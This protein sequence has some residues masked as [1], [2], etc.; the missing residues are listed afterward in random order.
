MPQNRLKGITIELSGDSTKLQASLKG[1][2]SEI[3]NTQSQLKDVERLLKLD[4]G[5]TELLAQKHKLLGQ[6]VDATKRKLE[7]LKQ[8]NEQVSRSAGNYD[9]WKAKYDPIQKEITETQEHLKKLKAQAA[10]AEKQLAEGKISQEKYDAIQTELKETSDHLKDLKQQARD[11][12]EEFGHPVSPEQYDALQREIVETTAELKKLEDQARQSGT[13]VQDIAAKGEKLKDLGGKVENAGKALLPVTGAVVGLGTAAVKTTADFDSSMSKVSAVS[14]ATGEELDKLRAKAREMGET[15]Q[16]SASEAADAMNYMAMAGWKTKDMLDGIDGIMNLAAASGEDLATTSDI[17]TD[18]LTAFGM[19]ADESGHFADIL[20]AASSNANTNVSMLG[21]SFKYVAPVAGAMGYNAEDVSLALGLMANSGIKASSAGTSLRNILTNM[22]NP[23]DKMSAAMD[24]LGIELDDGKGNM[25]SLREIMQNLRTGFGELKIPAD[26]AAAA[27]AD[28]DKQLEDGTIDQKE[29][30]KQVADLT[31]RVFGAE[32]AVKAQTAAMLAGKNGMSGLMALINASDEDY[33]KLTGA[34]DNCS[35]TFVKT[36]DGA[37]LPMSEALEQGI[38]WVEGYN[39]ASEQMAATM[40]DN[41]GGQLKILISQLQELA[42]SLGEIMMPIIRDIVT[43]LQGLVD[44]LNG[45]DDGTKRIIIT[46]AAVA[47]ALGPL[48]IFVGKV[49]GAVGTIMT[50]APKIQGALTLL[51]GTVFP[52]VKAALASLWGVLMANP[53]ILIVAAVAALVAAFIYFWNTSEGFRQF[54]INLWENI[55]ATAMAVWE[56][57]S[58]FFQTA[59]E[60]IVNIAATIWNGLKDFFSGLWAGIQEI[61]STV[62][63]TIVTIVTTY[64]TIYRT[65]I[66]TVLSAIRT[67]ITTIWN[68]IKTYFTAVFKGILAVVRAYFT[69]YKTV[70]TTVLKAIRT[71]VTTIWKA[72]S[73]FFSKVLGTIGTN[74]QKS[75]AA[76][77]KAISDR[78]SAVSKVVKAVWSAI[79]TIFGNSL[80]AVYNAVVKVFLA[81]FNGIKRVMKAVM[82]VVKNAFT[83]VRNFIVGLAKSAYTWGRD[84]IMG[85]VKGIRSAIGSVKNAVTDV[86]NSIK[87]ILHFSVPDEG[88]LTDYENWMPD[89][90]R[91]LA[92]G[93]E[94]NRPLVREAM[95]KVADDIFILP[96]SNKIDLSIPVDGDASGLNQAMIALLLS[97]MQPTEELVEALEKL[98]IQMDALRT[99]GDA[100]EAF[101]FILGEL[102]APAEA[103][104]GELIAL[105]EMLTVGALT[106]DEYSFRLVDLARRSLN[107]ADAARVQAAALLVAENGLTALIALASA[108]EEELERL[109][110][111]VTQVQPPELPTLEYAQPVVPEAEA[112][113]VELPTLTYPQPIVPEAEIPATH[114]PAPDAPDLFIPDYA[115]QMRRAIDS[116]VTKIENAR[117]PV[118]SAMAAL[119]ASLVLTPTLEEIDLPPEEQLQPF[120]LSI[121]PEMKGFLGTISS[122]MEVSRALLGTAMEN[123]STDLM[124]LPVAQTASVETGRADQDSALGGTLIAMLAEYL[125]YLPRL[126]QLQVRL[127]NGTLVGQLAPG[128]DERLGLLAKRQ[129]RQ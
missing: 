65:I 44:W 37:I 84:L 86:A 76:I 54:W 113:D 106:E 7:A 45:L 14:G 87:S 22:A 95:G 77:Q 5:N 66:T 90:L 9:A 68:A 32:G 15:T 50:W 47:A 2:T 64:F 99:P 80:K 57:L 24:K 61:F 117:A 93:I 13:A 122:T 72:I 96:D 40:N 17:V 82:T 79:R 60:T 31:E 53:I 103:V 118:Q 28:L 107:V 92:Q 110:E 36:A 115:S 119:S 59:W 56:A 25:L 85:I 35:Q 102:K 18:A 63:Q 75:F 94:D 71:V 41:L 42:I 100:L 26:E 129:R 11:V 101:R 29:Y 121:L 114:L 38:D 120:T 62:L 4:P 74:V 81:I 46:V 39:G 104:R 1:V 16:F 10:D 67:V 83:A 58:G 19:S 98:G 73:G 111:G 48:L 43:K 116:I 70:I 125:P 123:G 126:A 49:M 55:K 105:N 91:G 89:F 3:R 30:D 20:A 12:D 112:P 6:E 108:A 8:A 69:A 127:D 52:A 88:P 128:M 33:D 109:T 34:I 23:T 78:L 97:L 124:M 21:E 51:S 27:F